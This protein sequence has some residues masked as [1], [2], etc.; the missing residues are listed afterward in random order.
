MVLF[1]CMSYNDAL[2]LYIRFVKTSQMV[3]E[4]LSGHDF[5]GEIFEGVI[6]P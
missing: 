3:S 1:L 6:I 4:L 2:Y 5:H